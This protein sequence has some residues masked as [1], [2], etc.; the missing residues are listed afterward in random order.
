MANTKAEAA[1]L[2]TLTS[3]TPTEFFVQANKIR[4]SV[5]KW[6]TV[7]EL[8]KIRQT[9]P[10]IKPIP[11]DASDEER[12][13]IAA[14]NKAKANEQVMKNLS[15]LLDKA[16]EEHPKETL[17]I[18]ALTCFVE[19]KNVDAYPMTMY[20][21]AIGEVINNQDILDFFG[22]LAQLGQRNGLK[23]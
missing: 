1:P 19:P 16:L 18:L 9:K 15:S 14:E 7:T 21:K 4:K 2:K 20:L 12:A 3:C 10:D 6:A 5:E 8:Q 17:E 11:F 13:K 22:S 23:L